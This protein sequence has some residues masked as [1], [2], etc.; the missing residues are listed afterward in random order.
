L[1]RLSAARSTPDG[2]RSVMMPAV[3]F[4]MPPP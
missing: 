2:A 3:T 4:S 1:F